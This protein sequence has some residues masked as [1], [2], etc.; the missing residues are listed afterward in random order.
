[1]PAYAPSIR[2]RELTNRILCGAWLFNTETQS[3]EDPGLGRASVP[4]GYKPRALAAQIAPKVRE[5][6]FLG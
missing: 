5:H 1:M 4:L 6:G 2:K 3:H